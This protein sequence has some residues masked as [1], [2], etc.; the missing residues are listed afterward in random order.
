MNLVNS[1]KATFKKRPGKK[2]IYI[3]CMILLTIFKNMPIDGEK[4]AE[5]MYVKRAF[6]WEVDDLSYYETLRSVSSTIGTALAMPIF[7]YFH[8]PDNAII[9]VSIVSC[10][11]QRIMKWL[12]KSGDVFLASTAVGI[13]EN[14]LNAPTDTQITRCVPSEELGKVTNQK[15]RI[16]YIIFM[17]GVCHIIQLAVSCTNSYKCSLHKCL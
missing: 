7:H 6:Q 15:L 5:F 16:T 13:L 8:T 4:T 10:V 17:S 1:L 11:S 3:L 2:N 14:V 12:A 9:L